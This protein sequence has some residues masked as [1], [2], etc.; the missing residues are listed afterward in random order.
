[1]SAIFFAFIAER[2]GKR[3]MGLWGIADTTIALGILDGV[4]ILIHLNLNFPSNFVEGV[5]WAVLRIK[6]FRRDF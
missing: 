6:K 3:P 4:E 2:E 1:L 5:V